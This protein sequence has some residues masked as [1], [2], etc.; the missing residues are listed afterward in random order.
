MRYGKKS[1]H[2]SSGVPRES[3]AWRARGP[4]MAVTEAGTQYLAILSQPLSC[5]ALRGIF[6]N[7]SRTDTVTLLLAIAE[8]SRPLLTPITFYCVLYPMTSQEPVPHIGWL[9]TVI[10][11]YN[12]IQYAGPRLPLCTIV[13]S[14]GCLICQSVAMCKRRTRTNK[15]ET[16]GRAASPFLASVATHVTPRLNQ[17]PK[18]VGT[19]SP[20]HALDY[21]NTH[22]SSF[23]L[24]CARGGND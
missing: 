6:S 9:D 21:S 14:Y 19:M 20:P 13:F 24:T 7:P 4:Q 17:K 15:S 12:D 1:C 10:G 3:T 23:S 11:A 2:R 5:S 16:D 18:L 8:P 22:L